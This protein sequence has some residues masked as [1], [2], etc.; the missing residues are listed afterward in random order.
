MDWSN[1]VSALIGG[2]LALSG[3]PVQSSMTRRAEVRQR[4]DAAALA[5][6]E[7][8]LEIDDFY[9]RY[10]DPEVTVQG[11][12]KLS[13]LV[14]RFRIRVALIADAKLREQLSFIIRALGYTSAIRTFYGDGG[15]QAGHY[16]CWWGEDLLGSYLRGERLPREPQRVL[17]YRAAIS[18]ADEIEDEHRREL[19]AQRKQGI[20]SDGCANGH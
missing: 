2:A 16:L 19:E 8:L 9:N 7:L 6:Q 4:T 11:D 10:H 3:L 5:A 15:I 20:G 17:D 14:R 13:E 1:I 12:E 18:E